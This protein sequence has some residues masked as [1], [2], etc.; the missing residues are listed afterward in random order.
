MKTYKTFRAIFLSA[1]LV[2][3]I[4]LAEDASRSR[5][6]NV[7]KGGKI[8]VNISVGDIKV[9]PWDKNEIYIKIEGLDKEDLEKVQ[10]EQKGNTVHVLFPSHWGNFSGNVRF[11]INVPLEFNLD[12][13]TS[14]GDLLIDGNIKGSIRGKTSGGDIRT[15]DVNG[16]PVEAITSGGDI[17]VGQ[18]KG[19]GNLKTAGGD[20]HIGNVYGKLFVFTSGGD[21]KIE[22]V[23]KT[24]EA[25][26]AGGDIRVGNIGGNAQ[27]STSGGDIY[28]GDIEGEAEIS[29]AG[30]DIKVDKIKNKGTIKTAGGDIV[31]NGANVKAI[32]KT[33]GGDIVMKNIYGSVEGKTSGGNI[34][35]ELIPSGKEPSR[36]ISSGGDIK[37]FIDEKSKA[38][39]EATIKISGFPWGKQDFIVKSEFPQESYVTNNNEIHAVYKLNGGGGL[40]ELITSNSNIEILKLRK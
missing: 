3:S 19:D 18:I 23:S 35:A 1:I 28:L 29:T 34:N 4:L 7:N 24:L 11:N 5:S 8:K 21:I 36:L 2:S 14:G 32:V 20:I 27:I 40:V 13:N 37:L 15:A 26:T 38:T 10:M 17:F 33:S 9:K 25:K 16:G 12:M 22:S 30:G 6:F 31:L 39:I